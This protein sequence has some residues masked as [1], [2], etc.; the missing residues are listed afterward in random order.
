MENCKKTIKP[1]VNGKAK[2]G[3]IPIMR[4]IMGTGRLETDHLLDAGVESEFADIFIH[5]PT[6]IYRLDIPEGDKIEDYYASFS[7]T[8]LLQLFPPSFTIDGKMC[9]ISVQQNGMNEFGIG[10]IWGAIADTDKKVIA[11]FEGHPVSVL[12]KLIEY[13]Y[14]NADREREIVERLNG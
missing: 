2:Y 3:R 4:K 9:C 5:I 13:I 1:S 11:Q 14:L 7:T 8:R 12:T 6:G 10:T